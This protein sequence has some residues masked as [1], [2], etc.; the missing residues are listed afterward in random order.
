MKDFFSGQNYWINIDKPYGYSS[1]K[2]VAI[3]KRITKAKKVGHA[4]TLDPLATGVLPIAV[5][6]ATKTCDLIMNHSKKYYFEISWGESRD[7]Y[8][9]EGKIIETSINRPT[10]QEIINI[11]PDFLGKIEQMPPKFSAIK[12]NGQK[13][14]NLAR[15]NQDF[16]LKSR[17]IHIT[18]IRLIFNNKNHAAFEVK[19]SKGTYVRA[20]CRDI[21][22]KTGTCGYISVL[23]RLKTGNFDINNTIS[24]DKLK[25]LVNINAINGSIFKL[26]DVLGFMPEITLNNEFAFKV[27]NGQTI[28]INNLPNIN[29]NNLIK[30]I[31]N[32][33]L[34]G[35]GKIN[36][37]KLKPINI[38]NN[39]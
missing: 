29:Q 4:G 18:E 22:L 6:K 32:D 39:L 15:K 33:E 38:F 30:I 26:R 7:S 1:A 9:L 23:K 21:A 35:L 28:L 25:N 17:K 14:Y 12:I 11:L 27:K 36:Q 20:L 31:N 16:E 19:C 3:V 34:I 2:I 10:N 37:D 13:A 8:D 5:N 24:L